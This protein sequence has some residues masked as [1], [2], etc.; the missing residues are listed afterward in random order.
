[1]FFHTIPY[2]FDDISVVHEAS[3]YASEDGFI[4]EK[5]CTR[6]GQTHTRFFDSLRE[7]VI[8]HYEYMDYVILEKNHPFEDELKLAH[9]S[10]EQIDAAI[11]AIEAHFDHKIEI[12]HNI[13][14]SKW[15]EPR[16]TLNTV[17]WT[18]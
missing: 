16:A 5:M 13:R 8:W 3:V 2:R 18:V 11:Q 14:S 9:P 15:D 1:M 4:S 6:T 7:F 10:Q 17:L 12:K